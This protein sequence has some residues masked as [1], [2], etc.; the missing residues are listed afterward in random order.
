MKDFSFCAKRPIPAYYQGEKKRYGLRKARRYDGKPH[1]THIRTF[2][3][4]GR[5]PL[6]R[7]NTSA[8]YAGKRGTLH[9]NAT[10]IGGTWL[11]RP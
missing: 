5:M 10:E 1:L 3:R 8:S 9:E 6:S 7:E 4:K 2:K 11:E